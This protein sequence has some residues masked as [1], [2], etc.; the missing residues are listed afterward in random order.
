MLVHSL[1]RAREH[2]SLVGAVG[3]CDGK[4]MQTPRP[5]RPGRLECAGV[6]LGRVDADCA[7]ALRAGLGIERDRLAADQ[8]VEVQ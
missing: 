2:T 4:Q 6:W 8:A 3:E 7:V 5:R 1:R